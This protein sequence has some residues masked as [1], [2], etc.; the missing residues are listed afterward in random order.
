MR[1]INR[2]VSIFFGMC[3]LAPVA[4]G[5][6]LILG[7]ND[8]S[9][10]SADG[11]GDG[12]GEGG[13]LEA[14]GVDDPSK[15]SSLRFTMRD[16]GVHFNQLIEFRIIDN[17][18]TIQTRGKIFPVDE[19]GRESMTVN[20]PGALPLD[21]R[22][23]R[24]DFYGDMNHSGNYDG[25]GDVLR[26]DHAWRISPLED[27]PAGTFPHVPNLVQVIFEHSKII[28]DIDQWPLGTKNPA[29]ATGLSV[30]VSFSGEKMKPYR[31]KLLQVRVGESRIEHTV[32]V[33]R[34]PQVPDS[35]FSATIEGIL[36]PEVSYFVDVYVD[37]NGNGKYDNPAV[38]AQDADLGWRIPVKAT[39][40]DD[41]DAG[42]DAQADAGDA[43]A[44]ADAAVDAATPPS[45]PL[46]GIS[47]DFDP[48]GAVPSNT[49]VG[50]P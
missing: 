36:E 22:P 44:D 34:Q 33:Y 29:K 18:N 45:G 49:D 21:N 16:M 47:I 11:G 26:Q 38:L 48:T 40:P 37:A 31:G 30:R 9:F 3:A 19:T 50:E 8:F 43:G 13:G 4:A 46:Y 27:T 14:G 41:L 42:S 1:R 28:T 32:G 12:S 20:V 39:M 35:D 7:A 5:C 15:P 10:G 23:Y 25:I 24:L 2:A 6:H 17:Q